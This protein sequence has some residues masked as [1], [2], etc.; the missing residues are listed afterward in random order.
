M[1]VDTVIG[2]VHSSLSFRFSWSF[3]KRCFWVGI[4]PPGFILAVP[5]E[6]LGLTSARRVMHLS[7]CPASIWEPHFTLW[8]DFLARGSLSGVLFLSPSLLPNFTSLRPPVGWCL[9]G[10]F[11]SR[12]PGVSACCSAHR[13]SSSKCIMMTGCHFAVL[14]EMWVWRG[15]CDLPGVSASLLRT[16]PGAEDVTVGGN[17]FG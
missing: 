16:Q 8:W 10:S 11:L 17:E 12:R 6:V 14:H 1:A 3:R 7:H 2:D 15:C 5:C 4:F 13:V 9:C